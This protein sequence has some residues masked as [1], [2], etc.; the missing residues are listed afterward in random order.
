MHT[1]G[2]KPLDRPS[3]RISLSQRY[4]QTKSLPS[5]RSGDAKK[6]GKPDLASTDV[7]SAG[8]GEFKTLQYPQ[9][10]ANDARSVQVSTWNAHGNG[11]VLPTVKYAPSGRLP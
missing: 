4:E 11:S 9:G 10:I 6:A 7:V 8:D 2:L 3:T 5:G 1:D